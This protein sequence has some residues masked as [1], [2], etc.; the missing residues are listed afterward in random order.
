MFKAGAQRAA[1]ELG[2]ILVAPDT[3][4]R[5]RKIEREKEHWTFGEGASFYFNATKKPWSDFYSM[6]DYIADELPT[7]ID[8]NFPSGKKCI[9]GHSMGGHGA[10][11]IGLKNPHLFSSISAFAP[12]CAPTQSPWGQSAINIYLNDQNDGNNY[13]T[14]QLLHRINN[15]QPVL[16]DQGE[17]DQFLTEQLRLDDLAHIAKKKAL[18]IEIRRHAGYDHSYFFIATFIESHLLF[19]RRYA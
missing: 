1:E 8:N 16:I 9:M 11:V 2:L 3:S 15:H 17:D 5:D 19:H 10:L 4:P 14:V 13:D 6:Y 18:P 7:L 12:I